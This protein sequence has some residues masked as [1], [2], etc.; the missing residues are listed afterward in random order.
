MD[1]GCSG[2]AVGLPPFADLAIVDILAPVS[3][4]GADPETVISMQI[5]NNGFY[6]ITNQDTVFINYSVDGGSSVFGNLQLEKPLE[7]GE[8]V[9][10]SFF[11]DP[12]DF[13]SPG[14]YQV[15]VSLIYALD[16]DYSNNLFRSDIEIREPADV[17]IGGGSDTLI[18][19]LPLTLDAGLGFSSYQWQDMS[20]G[21]TFEVIAP[22][23]Y[24]VTVT[25]SSGCTGRDSVYVD[26][27]TS[28]ISHFLSNGQVRIYPN[29]VRDQ[30]NINFNLNEQKH[31][32]L[33]MYSLTNSLL[34]RKDFKQVQ[35]S[36]TNI[37]VQNLVPGSYYLRII[38]DEATNN[39]I[40]I[41]E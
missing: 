22:G 31:I 35:I 24:S 3:A 8:T 4:C 11:N 1:D 12:Y 36:E 30:L 20:T 21:T 34:F 19:G 2:S 17:E 6:R 13:S 5:Q 26:E 32:I 27:Q 29:P 23:W 41:V 7:P 33:E 9:V 37:D 16:Q 40:L 14:S 28:V 15:Q 38:M 10:A 18:T 25:N 39:F